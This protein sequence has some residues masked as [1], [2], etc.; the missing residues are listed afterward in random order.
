WVVYDKNDTTK[1]RATT[2]PGHVFEFNKH[3]TYNLGDDT[4]RFKVC[5]YAYK[6]IPKGQ[7][8]WCQD[9][10]C[11]YITN[12]FLT[13]IKIYNVFTPGRDGYNDVFKIDIEGEQKY[14]LTIFNRWGTKVFYSTDKNNMWNGKDNNDGAECANGTY[15]YVFNYRLRGQN[16]ATQHGTVTLI[17]EQ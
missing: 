2:Y 9:K 15:F 4:G 1:V 11:D 16:D 6:Y 14:E 13:R 17:R 8:E 10:F 12:N 3:Y 7:L 5:L